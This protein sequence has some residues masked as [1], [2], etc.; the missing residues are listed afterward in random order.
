[1]NTCRNTI[2]KMDA[3]GEYRGARC[4]K[5]VHYENIEKYNKLNGYIKRY[6]LRIVSPAE[7]TSYR[8][9]K[10]ALKYEIEI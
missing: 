1:M 9:P 6:L 5:G 2:N 8:L 3:S 7:A 10:A 4:V